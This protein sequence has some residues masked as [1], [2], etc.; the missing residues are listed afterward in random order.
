MVKELLECWNQGLV[1]ASC[2]AYRK[3]IKRQAGERVGSN[4]Y[5]GAIQTTHMIVIYGEGRWSGSQCKH[6]TKY[7]Q[8]N[9]PPRSQEREGRYRTQGTDPLT[10]CCWNMNV[11]GGVQWANLS[12]C[13]GSSTLEK[14]PQKHIPLCI[15]ATME[16]GAGDKHP[17]L[18]YKREKLHLFMAPGK[19]S[20]ILLWIEE[21]RRFFIKSALLKP[22]ISD[23]LLSSFCIQLTQW[24]DADECKTTLPHGI[25][26]TSPERM[27][28][29]LI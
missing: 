13:T 10:D 19:I 27:L 6:K 28:W 25:W 29:V 11:P 26:K 4:S 16:H 14:T 17:H 12:E 9:S 2:L 24:K 21:I 8:P 20:R 3:E 5:Q 23:S 7:R 1:L 15:S 18:W 22:F